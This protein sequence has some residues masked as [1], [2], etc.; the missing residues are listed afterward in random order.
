MTEFAK[1]V[2]KYGSV[3]LIALTGE[4][5]YKVRVIDI[6]PMSENKRFLD[7]T[8]QIYV[9]AKSKTKAQIEARKLARDYGNGL[10][11]ETGFAREAELELQKEIEKLYEGVV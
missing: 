9:F 8:G 6:D 1:F 11:I 4:K 5:L 2:Q 10:K 7:K 3:P